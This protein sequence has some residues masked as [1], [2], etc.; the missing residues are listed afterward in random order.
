VPESLDFRNG[1]PD[2]RHR[3][4]A[5]II[6]VVPTIAFGGEEGV[7]K[8]ASSLAGIAFAAA[9]DERHSLAPQ[10]EAHMDNTEEQ[11]GAALL[12]KGD[13]LVENGSRTEAIAVYDDLIGRFGNATEAPMREQVV[14]ALFKKGKATLDRSEEIAVYDDLIGRFG[15]ATEAPIREQVANALL[16][17][18]EVFFVWLGR[19]TEAIAV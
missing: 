15:N 9:N 16:R 12:D 19:D 17:K 13:I 2:F 3:T 6:L 14:I 7:P 8:A 5:G 11:I 18:G 10:G 1:G 4:A